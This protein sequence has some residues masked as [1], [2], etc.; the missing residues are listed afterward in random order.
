MNIKYRINE[1]DYRSAAMLELRKR[2]RLSLFEYYSPYIIAIV[3]IAA[4][5]IPDDFDAFL[6]L[7]I[8]PIVAAI[9]WMRRSR[10]GRD[11]RRKRSHHL[12]HSLD[13]DRNGLRLE[14]SDSTTRTA[15]QNYSKFA[16]DSNTFVLFQK[17]GH[18]FFAIPKDHLSP[19]QV[20]ELGSMLSSRLP[21]VQ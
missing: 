14:T 10:F 6:T 7:G 1:R 16:E 5:M 18:E 19:P 15:W 3:W 9:L 8:I 11:F 13:V 12:L 20:D 17:T 21:R 2:S 4:S